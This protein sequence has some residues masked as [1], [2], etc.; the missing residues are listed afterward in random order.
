LTQHIETVLQQQD[1]WLKEV[2]D[3]DKPLPA[4][5]PVAAL[6]AYRSEA[7][8]YQQQ[9]IQSAVDNVRHWV[10]STQQEVNRLL[11]TLASPSTTPVEMTFPIWFAKLG[12]QQPWQ[13]VAIGPTYHVQP[14]TANQHVN[15]QQLPAAQPWLDYLTANRLATRHAALLDQH[16]LAFDPETLPEQAQRLADQQ[17][18][19][20]AMYDYLTNGLKLGSRTTANPQ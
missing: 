5:W 2:E 18:I 11:W 4:S 9:Q 7:L 15:A 19:D 13:I 6:L 16:T 12:S 8:Q 17:L 14:V 3:L 1:H 10:A 20:E